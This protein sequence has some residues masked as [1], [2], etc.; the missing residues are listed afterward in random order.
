M[1]VVRD[2]DDAVRKYEKLGL[3]VAKWETVDNGGLVR[4]A[5]LR[6][7]PDTFIE[8]MEPLEGTTNDTAR[9]LAKKGQGVYAM[10]Y[11]VDNLQATIERLSEEGIEL[12]GVGAEPLKGGSLPPGGRNLV[13]VHPRHTP[14]V[15]LNLQDTDCYPDLEL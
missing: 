7:G 12:I 6:T 9:F 8:L 3:R 4:Q 2:I 13:W 10:T 1:I 5:F 11:Q 14:G 15:Y